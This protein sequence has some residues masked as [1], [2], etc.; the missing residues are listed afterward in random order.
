[1]P[2][3]C[4]SYQNCWQMRWELLPM[5]FSC[6]DLASLTCQGPEDTRGGTGAAVTALLPIPTPHSPLQLWGKLRQTGTDPPPLAQSSTRVLGIWMF[7]MEPPGPGDMCDPRRWLVSQPRLQRGGVTVTPNY[8][9][10]AQAAPEPHKVPEPGEGSCTTS[11]DMVSCDR[12]PAEPR[13]RCRMGDQ[14]G[15][16]QE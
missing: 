11:G 9:G 6:L 14:R 15:G 12:H 4:R 3:L 16:G 5:G 13:A 8:G 10:R 7:P 1:M 2:G